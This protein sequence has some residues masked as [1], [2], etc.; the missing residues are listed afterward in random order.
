MFIL[1]SLNKNVKK[2]SY[3]CALDIGLI[4]IIDLGIVSILRHTSNS[5]SINIPLVQVLDRL[6]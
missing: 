4:K 6:I 2:G 5:F 1:Y 3:L